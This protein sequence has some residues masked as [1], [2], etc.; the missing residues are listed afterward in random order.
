MSA[1][2]LGYVAIFKY[3]GEYLT[4]MKEY[5]IVFNSEKDTDKMCFRMTS[6]SHAATT[7]LFEKRKHRCSDFSRRSSRV[8]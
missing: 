7:I 8:L 1:D 2:I 4:I 5:D 6:G 3:N